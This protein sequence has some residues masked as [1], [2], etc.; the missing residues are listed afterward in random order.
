MAEFEGSRRFWRE[1]VEKR[2]EPR[3]IFSK[4]GRQLKQQR[5]KLVAKC[6]G[7]AT[8]LGGEILA[9]LQLRVVRDAARCLQREFERRRYLLRPA[10]QQFL[11]R[12]AIERVVDFDGGKTRGVVGEHLRGRKIGRIEAPLPLRIVVAGSTDEDRHW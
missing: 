4:R 1:C 5:A 11:R 3:Q 8:E 7:N 12:H 10:S 6:R 2:V 9:I